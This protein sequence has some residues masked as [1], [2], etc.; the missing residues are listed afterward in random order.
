ML[1]RGH[2]RLQTW[3]A[4]YMIVGRGAGRMVAEG[5]LAMVVPDARKDQARR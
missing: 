5:S 1:V 4:G 3:E 2:G